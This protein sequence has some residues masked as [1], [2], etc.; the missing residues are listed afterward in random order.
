MSSIADLIA[1]DGE[2][3]PVGHTFKPI[4]VRN[5]DG[6]Q[7]GLYREATVGVPLEAQSTVQLSQE[8]LKSGVHKFV[9]RITLPVMESVSGQNSAG[10]TAPPKVAY[11][12]TGEVVMFA[13]PRS[14][15]QQRRNLRHLLINALYGSVV[16]AAVNTNGP[17]ADLFD[18]GI[19][20]T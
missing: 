7:V 20:P 5:E 4:Y 11:T 13:P 16:A 2:S 8:N 3:T 9:M 14:T 15:P 18:N 6:K 1:F 10:Y 19:S 17:S 12:V